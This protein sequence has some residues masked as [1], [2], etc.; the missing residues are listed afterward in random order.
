LIRLF[1]RSPSTIQLETERFVLKSLTRSELARISFPWTEDPAVMEPLELRAGGWTPRDWRRQVLKPNNR[2]K[3]AFGI[4]DRISGATI[5][6]ESTHISKTNVA[7]LGVAIGERHWW[8]KGVVVESR[9]AI[10]D[11]LF[12]ERDCAR[13][14]GIVG[15]RNLPSISNYLM[16]GFQH[17]GTLRGHFGRSDLP[18]GDGMVFGILREEWLNRRGAGVRE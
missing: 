18:R 7:L 4:V 16:L 13:A 11:F 15:A 17:E 2:D 6:Y 9:S 8:G 10:L 1:Q 5:G 14:W 3:F 12:G